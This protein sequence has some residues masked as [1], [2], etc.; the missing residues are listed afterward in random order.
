MALNISWI[1]L[2]NQ[3]FTIKSFWVA[4]KLLIHITYEFFC[5]FWSNVFSFNNFNSLCALYQTIFVFEKK[6]IFLF[7]MYVHIK[8]V[9]FTQRFIWMNEISIILEK[10]A[11]KKT[12]LKFQQQQQQKKW[13]IKCAQQFSLVEKFK[14]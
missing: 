7:N 11:E 10:W 14:C 2:L 9:S 6:F 13:K 5:W 4:A 1:L 12:D 3:S 8:I